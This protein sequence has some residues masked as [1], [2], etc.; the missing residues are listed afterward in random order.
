MSSQQLTGTLATTTVKS[1]V[2]RE[3][4]LDIRHKAEDFWLVWEEVL[5]PK[6]F[7][8]TNPPYGLD[9]TYWIQAFL[10]FVVTFDRPFLL[11]PP[12]YIC[13]TSYFR[14]AITN[15]SRPTELH[16]WGL[17]NGYPM[18]KEGDAEA[19]TFYGLTV[20]AYYPKAWKSSDIICV[21]KKYLHVK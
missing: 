21:T 15:C 7:I 20:V 9:A 3:I 4:G 5:T 6:T 14:E 10:T 16:I 8:S 17:Q 2:Y 11:M 1:L 18:K 13:S 19:R 12:N